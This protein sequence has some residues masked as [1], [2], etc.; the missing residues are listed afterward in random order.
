MIFWMLK[1]K[2]GWRTFFNTLAHNHS[3]ALYFERTIK[4]STAPARA[5]NPMKK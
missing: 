1:T 2:C 4:V 3:P 5:L